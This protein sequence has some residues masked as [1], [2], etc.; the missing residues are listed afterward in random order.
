MEE[1]L[2]T[3]CE[4]L[5]WLHTYFFDNFAPD[6]LSEELRMKLRDYNRALVLKHPRI[7]YRTETSG[8]SYRL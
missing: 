1:I 5:V 4:I 7:C 3:L 8:Q 2:V 6:K